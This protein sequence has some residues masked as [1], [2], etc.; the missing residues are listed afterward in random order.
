MKYSIY[1]SCV[2]RDI[3][4]VTSNDELVDSYIARSSLHSQFGNK[5][6]PLDLSSMSLG[7]KSWQERML[8]GD[9]SKDFPLD[10]GTFL[11]DFIDERFRILEAGGSYITE[12]L[13][14]QN[15]G[16]KEKFDAKNGFSRGSETEMKHWIES[17]FNFKKYIV[18]N[19]INV[20]LHKAYFARNYRTSKGDIKPLVRLEFV[21]FCN[22]LLKFY[23]TSFENIVDPHSVISVDSKYLVADEDHRWGLAPFHYIPEYYTKAFEAI[24]DVY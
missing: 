6:I 22:K 4:S 24:V 10:K 17:C 9:L 3:F 21:D 13:E 2:T 20:V 16:L 14:F 18:K 1:G 23:Y 11:I 15:K 7:K 12:S 5:S 8:F 19:E